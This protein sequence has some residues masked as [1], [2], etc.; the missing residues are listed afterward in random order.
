MWEVGDRALDDILFIHFFL[1]WPTEW[2]DVLFLK[3]EE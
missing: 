2:V 3:K 1:V